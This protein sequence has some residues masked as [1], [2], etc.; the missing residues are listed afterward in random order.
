VSLEPPESLEYC[1]WC[2]NRL[3]KPAQ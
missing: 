3:P 2:N 1:P